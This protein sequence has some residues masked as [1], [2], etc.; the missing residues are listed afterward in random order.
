MT[1]R[2]CRAGLLALT[3]SFGIACSDA[4]APTPRASVEALGG[5]SAVMR[6]R[7]E[8]IYIA[9][10]DGR[11]PTSLT[12]G[13][14]PSW[15]PDGR[16]I[17]FSNHGSLHVIYADGT[18]QRTLREGWRPSWSPDG[19]RLAF[20]NS[21]GIAIMDVDGN[22]VT[23]VIRHDFNPATYKLWDMGIDKASWSPDGRR[24]AFE[25]L[26][27]GDTEPAQIYVVNV[28]GTDVQRL[29]RYP[30]VRYAES[31]PSW[32]PDGMTVAHW[33][34][35]YGIALTNVAAGLSD[36]IYANFPF[37]AYGAKPEWSPDGRR[38]LFNSFRWGNDNAQLYTVPA[39]GGVAT[40]IIANGHSGDWSPDGSKI[41][42]VRAIR[43]K[44]K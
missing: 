33:S 38:I 27:D 30:N 11:N 37:V 16:R 21:S 22:S 17:A 5:F 6:E 10:A 29:A 42:F 43:S 40:Q 34:L 24:L 19:R 35:G 12:W 31:D 7:G 3:A 20:T 2:A 15:S 14:N 44:Q 1:F 41:V 36:R 9:D 39:T 23:T 18:N 28:D 25:H 8:R 32:S 13:S 26:G 4:T